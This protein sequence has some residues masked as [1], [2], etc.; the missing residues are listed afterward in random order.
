MGFASLLPCKNRG[1]GLAV[2][3]AI[4]LAMWQPLPA[5][6]LTSVFLGADAGA[7]AV[8]AGTPY[9]M[10]DPAWLTAQGRQNR[11]LFA[12]K[13]FSALLMLGYQTEGYQS[14]PPQVTVLKNFKSHH[15]AA[16]SAA[17]PT[18]LDSDCLAAL[19]AALVDREVLL[20]DLASGFPLAA[21]MVQLAANDVSADALAAIFWLPMTVVPD[22][23]RLGRDEL[24]QCVAGQ[25]DGFI[26]DA[27]GVDV[28]AWPTPL[29]YDSPGWYFVGA[30]FDPLVANSQ[31]PSAAVTVD[32][33]LHE[34][35][36]YLDGSLGWSANAAYP[37]QGWY[38][39]AAFNAISFDTSDPH[40]RSTSCVKRRSDDIRDW[41]SKYG[42]TNYAD[43]WCQSKY[44]L[45]G[46]T[47]TVENW[48]EAFQMYIT[49][50][51]DFRA[52]GLQ[53]TYIQAEY[54]WLKTNV[55]NGQEFDTDLP[56]G[57]NSGCNDLPGASATQPGYMRCDPAYIW[58]FTLPSGLV[59]GACGAASGVATIGAPAS[60]LCT[61]GA[62]GPVSAQAVP[63]S[64]QWSCRG[65]NGGTTATCSAPRTVGNPPGSPLGVTATAGD[66]F[67]TVSFS[68]PTDAGTQ[69]ID[70]YAVTCLPAGGSD[71]QGGTLSLTHVVSGLTNG[72]SYT[73]TVTAHN[74]FGN[75]PASAPTAAVT[76]SS[77]LIREDFDTSIPP[78]L[79]YP[80]QAV[81]EAGSGITWQ[82]AAGGSFPPVGAHSGAN[83]MVFNAH[84]T[85]SSIPRSRLVS[86]SFSLVGQSGARLSFWMY[87]DDDTGIGFV[88]DLLDIYV[89][90]APNA[91]GGTLLDTIPRSG[92]QSGP[93]Y[94]SGQ[95]F[96]YRVMGTIANPT[97]SLCGWQGTQACTGMGWYNYQFAIPASFSGAANYI[98]LV[99]HAGGNGHD[100]H[101]DD[102]VVAVPPTA[103]TIADV[104]AGNGQAVVSLLAPL[105]D[106]GSTITGYTVLATPATPGSAD[107]DAG[108]TSAVHH[109]TGLSN[110]V[111][112]TFT[113]TASNFAGTSSPSAASAAV[114][115]MTTPS[116]PQNLT[117]VAG[118]RSATV[119]FD[120]PADNGGSNVTGY[121]V[122]WTPSGG[123]D[124]DAG[125]M[126]MSHRIVGLSNG[127]PYTFYVSALNAAGAGSE[128]TSNV[129][130]PALASSAVV[131]AAVPNPGVYGQSV[132][133]SAQVTGS[134]P[135]GLVSF[136][137]N[138]ADYWLPVG[139]TDGHGHFQDALPVGTHTLSASYAGDLN[140]AASQSAD[141]V[142]QVNKAD[143]DVSLTAHSPSPS[144][145]GR[146]VAV[147]VTVA[148]KAPG[149]GYPGGTVTVG[150][151]VD[152]CQFVLWSATGCSLTLATTGT[153][154][155]VA[156]Y[157]GDPQFNVADSVA[158]SHVVNPPTMPDKPIING[159]APSRQSLTVS[160]LPPAS[161]GGADITTYDLSCVH[162]GGGTPAAVS[163]SS[164]P[165]SLGGLIDGDS[166]SCAVSAGNK[167]GMGPASDPVVVVPGVAQATLMLTGHSPEPSLVGQSVAVS[168][169]IGPAVKAE[170]L[171][172]GG[173][174]SCL[175]DSLGGIRCWGHNDRGQLGDGSFVDRSLPVPVA[176]LPGPASAIGAGE[177]H[178][179]AVVSGAVWC[180]G[181]NSTGQLGQSLATDRSP[182]P[183]TVTGVSSVLSVRGGL[184]FTCAVDSTG[185]VACWG[186]N[187]SGALGDG[188]GGTW[189]AVS[190]TPVAVDFSA[191]AVTGGV[192]SLSA[193]WGHV[194]AIDTAG[195]L[196]CW[197]SNNVG[198]L[199][200][201]T[202]TDR[203][204][205]VA[206]AIPPGLP[207]ATAIG[208]G[209]EHSCALS[210]TGAVWCWGGD[211]YDQLAMAGLPGNQGYSAVPVL[212]PDLPRPALALA[213]GFVGNCIAD[214][215]GAV[216]CW[217]MANF[218]PTGGAIQP[219]TVSMAGFAVTSLTGGDNH[220]CALSADGAAAC[221]GNNGYGQLG[222]AS[223][224][225]RASADSVTGF[226]PPGGV[227]H[228]SDGADSCDAQLPARSCSLSLSHAGSASLTAS[229]SGDAHYGAVDSSPVSHL[230]QPAA[231]AIVFGPVPVLAVG[232]TVALTAGG[233]ASGN[234]VLFTSLTPTVCSVLGSLVHGLQTGPCTVAADQSGS[235]DYL[236]APRASQ[237][238]PV[239][240]AVAPS[241]PSI[242]RLVGG[243]GRLKVIF[244]LAGGFGGV[245]VTDV[246][247]S[248]LPAGGAV[249]IVIHGLSSPLVLTG[250]VDGT[251][252]SCSLH[253]V[254]AAGSSPESAAAS[255]IVRAPALVP[256]LQMLLH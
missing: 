15:A 67:A 116:P 195:K 16:C 87:R 7:A 29:N 42:Y 204:R 103:P 43:S 54:D 48:A 115:P 187:S 98:V 156:H 197:G 104:V 160:F 69:P 189:P 70:G 37:H 151:G 64:W 148:V 72:T 213:A 3:L 218:I 235:A 129:A 89:N 147:T 140:N 71:V 49:A 159:A 28:P 207:S 163:G 229:Y 225:S 21:R 99:G 142:L 139:L 173:G 100:I 85:S 68:A 256:M 51:R 215:S 186:D 5:Q 196:F 224:V 97:A 178:A 220:V 245:P 30:Y 76:P 145:V 137:D 144:F 191:V 96:S 242:L 80:W 94:L 73:C 52:A 20:A 153:R 177:S 91:T 244:A 212:I 8:A 231:Q 60:G 143:V 119:S 167:T 232:G 141:Y 216:R 122:T 26:H 92:Y 110:G 237:S 128:A 14:E 111:S 81:V 175:L 227:L 203:P 19:D 179:C 199:G 82:S 55:F 194:C 132:T 169:R 22:A 130:T 181:D 248:C 59:N 23:V 251:R 79:P 125:T 62:T 192:A 65:L 236:A 230:V 252:Y 149:A 24:L 58:D 66:T 250:L 219:A 209:F 136:K 185:S 4:F 201:N 241:A 39:T 109:L 164:S 61:A 102:V 176:G 107:A 134:A 223:L 243:K 2:L 202:T 17:A 183:V 25:C 53:S 133:I 41:I 47:T 165:L 162:Q 171:A 45:T 135:T 106:G 18:V 238:F 123:V 180:W 240:A 10:N 233:G 222:D 33:V 205:P 166:Y 63:V 11:S 170:A 77:G 113:A 193:G 146:P 34:F 27:A 40:N 206:V 46:Y 101:V 124:L 168:A 247:V 35:A 114:L 211:D 31:M 198:Q 95:N 44:G 190:T 221:W 9:D 214:D 88:N 208:S 117:A 127:V 126:S 90:T 161:D 174:H 234:P 112:Y 182:I 120:A 154:S 131:V 249:P 226:E 78:G 32:T 188:L 86:P 217:G 246:V 12:Y 50:G 150:D 13:I 152:S 157:G 84:S 253:A 105:S 158:V 228:F 121:G 138:G 155:L 200:D 184:G 1:A 57:A 254:N 93:N 210:G 83:L 56:Q 36:H 118:I 75:G 74:P 255:V 6:A 172:A 108:T 38:N 239:L